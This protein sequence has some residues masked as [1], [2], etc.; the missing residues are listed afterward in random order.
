M[1]TQLF[2]ALVLGITVSTVLLVMVMGSVSDRVAVVGC[3]LL[4]PAHVAVLRAAVVYGCHA[5]GWD[6]QGMVAHVFPLPHNPLQPLCHPHCEMMM[7]TEVGEQRSKRGRGERREERR[8]EQQQ[9]AIAK[10]FFFFFFCTRWSRDQLC[11]DGRDTNSPERSD[12]MV[13]CCHTK[14]GSKRRLGL[15]EPAGVVASAGARIGIADVTA[16]A[17]EP[18]PIAPTLSGASIGGERA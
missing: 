16:C 9:K 10:P 8:M 5:N 18:E 17:G 6:W 2:L 14:V 13:A 4:L 12:S 3:W 7:G 1:A 11:W 15:L